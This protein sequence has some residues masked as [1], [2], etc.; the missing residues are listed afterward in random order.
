M[1]ARGKPG[2]LPGTQKKAGRPRLLA[3][4]NANMR[5]RAA[6]AVR[7][8]LVSRARTVQPKPSERPKPLQ[9]PSLRSR[10]RLLRTTDIP[11][12]VTSFMDRMFQNAS[13]PPTTNPEKQSKRKSL[14]KER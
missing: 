10:V 2:K 11:P 8:I 6:R 13:N 5:E 1:R 3:K 4:R 7:K 9:A 12:G 14:V